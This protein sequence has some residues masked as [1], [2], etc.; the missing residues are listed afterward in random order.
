MRIMIKHIYMYIYIYKLV[1]PDSI[2][3]LSL[4][5]TNPIQNSK[6]KANIFNH[7]VKK[8]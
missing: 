8:Q 6:E 2:N 7:T 1:L 5:F 3:F 4:K